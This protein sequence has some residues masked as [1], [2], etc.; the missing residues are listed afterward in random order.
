MLPARHSL[1]RAAFTELYGLNPCQFGRWRADRR[2]GQKVVRTLTTF[3]TGPNLVRVL[4]KRPKNREQGIGNGEG[5]HFGLV[6]RSEA[7]LR[8]VAFRLATARVTAPRRSHKSCVFKGLRQ[9]GLTQSRKG[10]KNGGYRVTT[11][12]PFSRAPKGSG[13][14]PQRTPNADCGTR[15]AERTATAS[16]RKGRQERQERHGLG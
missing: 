9:L 7:P 1:R 11:K 14:W 6:L 4:T 10:A 5:S 15:N 3:G 12:G 8:R 16:N 13:F 2:R